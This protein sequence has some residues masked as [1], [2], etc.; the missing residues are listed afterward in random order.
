MLTQIL[1]VC[2]F[3]QQLLDLLLNG[4]L[5]ILLEVSTG[6]LLLDAS[7]YLQGSGILNFFTFAW[8]VLAAWRSTL[9][10]SWCAAWGRVQFADD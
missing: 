8:D 10:T 9:A 6:E 5:D 3:G 2:R 4:Q 1:Q 7:K